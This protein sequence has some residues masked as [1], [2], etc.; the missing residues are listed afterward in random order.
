[1]GTVSVD[2]Q[3]KYVERS[4]NI[5]SPEWQNVREHHRSKLEFGNGTSFAIGQPTA[6]E[7]L[8]VPCKHTYV[9][10]ALFNCT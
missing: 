7:Y 8:I 9:P 4:K 10:F 5:I 6:S 2:F 3:P 1:M